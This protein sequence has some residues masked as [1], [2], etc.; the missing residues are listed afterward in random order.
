M[1]ESAIRPFVKTKCW[2]SFLL[3]LR[4]ENNFYF[5]FEGQKKKSVR[6]DPFPPPLQ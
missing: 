3:F 1:F 5:G 2:F 6:T 4:A